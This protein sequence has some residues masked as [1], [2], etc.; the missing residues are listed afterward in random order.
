RIAQLL[1]RTRLRLLFAAALAHALAHGAHARRLLHLGIEIG[2]IAVVIMMVALIDQEAFFQVVV[3]LVL[4]VAE[5]ALVLG[6]IPLAVVVDV[7]L[8]GLVLLQSVL[9]QQ[10]YAVGPGEQLVQILLVGVH[11]LAVLLVVV[12]GEEDGHHR[13]RGPD[14]EQR[15]R[16][17]TRGGQARGGGPGRDPAQR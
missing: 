14:P 13:Q 5:D 6:R 9:R 17:R 16:E 10:S 3:H 8:Q 15:R 4:A 2:A 1:G 7:G 12:D 11:G